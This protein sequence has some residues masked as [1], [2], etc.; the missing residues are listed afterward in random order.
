MKR[1]EL[2]GWMKLIATVAAL[3]VLLLLDVHSGVPNFGE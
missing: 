2:L 3:A 1:N